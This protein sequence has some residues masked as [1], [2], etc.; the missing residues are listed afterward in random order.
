M[1][2]PEWLMLIRHDV[3]AY[4]NMK[5]EKENDPLYQRFKKA[6]NKDPESSDAVTLA[7]A[8][9]EKYRMGVSD[10]D[11]PL[12]DETAERAY[13]TGVVLRGE[14]DAPHVI[15]H[16]PFLRVVGTLKGLKE[17][18]PEL[19][20]ARCIEDERIREQDHGLGL[21]YNDWRIFFTFHPEQRRLNALLG[22]YR[23]MWPQG[24][25]VPMVRD[26]NRLWM[27]TL[28]RDFPRRRV[29]A[30][31]HHLNILA[32]RANQERL[33]ER[34]FQHIDDHDKPINCGVTLYRGHPFEGEEGRLKLD[35]Y[36]RCY[37]D[38]PQREPVA[39]PFPSP[40]SEK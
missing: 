24:E 37:Y 5:N 22:H 6:Y 32:I 23:Y 31:T 27:S 3:S 9:Y 1:K 2:W 10:A 18:W 30:V 19:K 12:Q 15:F 25:N 11:T 13:Q 36:N 29:L 26:R 4:N 21:L 33:D 39:E 7:H 14:F 34:Q 40:I 16:S 35:F 28:V 8:V 38:K 17:G 20:D